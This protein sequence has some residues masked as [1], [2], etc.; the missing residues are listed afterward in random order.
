MPRALSFYYR[1]LSPMREPPEPRESSTEATEQP[2]R[3]SPNRPYK[4][5]RSPHSPGP[6]GVG[7]SGDE[8]NDEPASGQDHEKV[9]KDRE[10]QRQ[11]PMTE[12]DQELRETPQGAPSP[13]KGKRSG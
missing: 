12:P 5:H 2:G 13:P 7:C 9:E 8:L 6:G 10:K 4:A 1:T 3:W 11:A